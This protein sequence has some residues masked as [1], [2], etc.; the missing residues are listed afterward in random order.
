M[1]D[2]PTGAWQ[3]G[4]VAGQVKITYK[5]DEPGHILRIFSQDQPAEIELSDGATDTNFSVSTGQLG[6]EL[7]NAQ[8]FQ[9]PNFQYDTPTITPSENDPTTQTMEWQGRGKAVITNTAAPASKTLTGLTIN[10]YTGPDNKDPTTE[11]TANLT[12]SDGT[13]VAQ[14]GQSLIDTA[15]GAPGFE[16]PSEF[17]KG[18]LTSKQMA[19]LQPTFT[20]ADT[21][22]LKLTVS[23]TPHGTGPIPIAHD[24]WTFSWGLIPEWN[25]VAGTEVHAPAYWM[26]NENQRSNFGY[27]TLS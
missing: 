18:Q 16:A 4:V 19:L 14:Y 23:I 26:L 11:I 3:Y 12:K 15:P 5:P 24:T 6:L 2:V 25:H 13:L 20:N 8:P 1:V 7:W 17:Q 27:L 9:S 22:G 21:I 10:F